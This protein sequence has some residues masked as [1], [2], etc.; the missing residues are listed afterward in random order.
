MG[1]SDLMSLRELQAGCVWRKQRPIGEERT[2]FGCTAMLTSN[3][4]NNVLGDFHDE[5]R[6]PITYVLR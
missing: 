2:V 3:T 4:T 1:S 5:E 6:P